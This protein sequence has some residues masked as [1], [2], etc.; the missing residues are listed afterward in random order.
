MC[1]LHILLL[2]SAC[3][4]NGEVAGEDN[5]L[6]DGEAWVSTWRSKWL[7]ELLEH[8]LLDNSNVQ[9]LWTGYRIWR[10]RCE[11]NAILI[12]NMYNSKHVCSSCSISPSQCNERL[13]WEKKKGSCQPSICR[14]RARGSRRSRQS[15]TRRAKRTIFF[16]KRTSSP[17]IRR[18]TKRTSSQSR[19]SRR[20][21]KQTSSPSM[22]TRRC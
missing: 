8:G 4:G 16:T 9:I 18:A 11:A 12:C 13:R 17:S 2:K 3:R 6:S 5:V 1:S 15:R 7:L 22:R 21:T 14:K 20:A 19:S 10:M